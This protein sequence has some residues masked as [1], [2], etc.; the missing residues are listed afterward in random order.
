MSSTPVRA[1]TFETTLLTRIVDN[2]RRYGALH[3]NPFK[4]TVVKVDST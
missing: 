1:T 3:D 2:Q 4:Q